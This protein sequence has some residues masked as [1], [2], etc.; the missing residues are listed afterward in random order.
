MATE[1]QQDADTG[2]PTAAGAGEPT[3]TDQAL[4][5]KGAARRRLAS[6]G[7]SGV[8]M[9]LASQ[10]AMAA[11]VCESPSGSLSGGLASKK[12]GGSS[13]AGVS[14]GYWK[15]HK[16]AWNGLGVKWDSLFNSVFNCAG[17]PGYS[18]VSCGN[19]LTH[20]SFDTNNLGMHMMATLLNVRSKRIS[21]L[22]EAKLQEIWKS[23]LT[24][25]TY[26]PSK[27]A[28]PWTS[29]DIVLYLKS[30]MS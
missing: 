11:L 12:P 7:A 1:Q 5:S 27:G 23:W 22:T 17:R 16:S 3:S 2:L 8:L 24:T 30:T 19:I 29:A 25:G 10:S 26:T 18:T 28:T 9:T 14:P 20:Q 4:G 6:A 15:T 21:F 13:C